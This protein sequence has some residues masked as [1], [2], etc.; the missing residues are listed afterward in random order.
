MKKNT[1]VKVN[2]AAIVSAMEAN[3]YYSR[4]EAD[5]RAH[6]AA[7]AARAAAY[8]AALDAAHRRIYEKAVAA[9]KAKKA[10]A[11]KAVALA[12]YERR[13]ASHAAVTVSTR[14]RK[15]HVIRFMGRL[16]REAEAEA[17]LH[18][19]MAGCQQTAKA[20]C[21]RA[22]AEASREALRRFIAGA[23]VA[24]GMFALAPEFMA[25]AI[26]AMQDIL[27]KLDIKYAKK[28]CDFNVDAWGEDTFSFT[29]HRFDG[30]ETTEEDGISEFDL[31][32]FAEKKEEKTEN[33]FGFDLQRFAK[34]TKKDPFAAHRTNVPLI[35]ELTKKEGVGYV[36]KVSFVR[37]TRKTLAAKVGVTSIEVNPV[38]RDFF[39]EGKALRQ[40]SGVKK[41]YKKAS[42]RIVVFEFSSMNRAANELKKNAKDSLAMPLYMIE[43]KHGMHV[44]AKYEG[45]EETPWG[46]ATTEIFTDLCTGKDVDAEIVKDAPMYFGTNGVAANSAGQ[47][48]N[49]SMLAFR[50]N[51]EADIKAYENAM[52]TAT[53]GESK[54]NRNLDII[55]GAERADINTRMGSKLT[56]LGMNAYMGVSIESYIIVL[57]KNART[58]GRL[59]YNAKGVAIGISQKYGG[60]GNIKKLTERVIGY[61]AQSRPYTVKG[62]GLI[63]SEEEFELD[64]RKYKILKLDACDPKNYAKLRQ[65]NDVLSKARRER[66]GIKLDSVPGFKGYDAVQICRGNLDATPVFYGDLNAFKDQFDQRLG[67]GLN[68]V[69]IPKGPKSFND[70]TLSNQMIKTVLRAAKDSDQ[71]DEFNRVTKELE[72]R[73]L[74]GI[75]DMKEAKGF[76]GDEML[77]VS[78]IG[79]LVRQLN[80]SDGSLKLFPSVYRTVIEDMKLSAENMIERDK[81]H[82]NGIVTMMTSDP[83]IE[84]FGESVLCMEKNYAEVF[85]PAFERYA[86]E[87]G[88]TSREGIAI[89]HPAMGTCELAIIRFVSEEEMVERIAKLAK[90]LDSNVDF[91]DV[92]TVQNT[93]RTL[94]EGTV[95]IPG[96]LQTF[97]MI[98]AGADL[99]GDELI[100]HYPAAD[101]I[102]YVHII[103]NAVKAGKFAWRAVSI[104]GKKTGKA[105]VSKADNSTFIEQMRENIVGGNVA[106]GSITNVHRIMNEPL[107]GDG[108]DVRKA[109][110]ALFGEVFGMGNL[111]RKGS[112]V[113]YVSPIKVETNEYDIE[114]FHTTEDIVDQVIMAMRKASLTWENVVAAA[115]DWDIIGRHNQELTI[116]AQKKYYSVEHMAYVSW[117]FRH[118]TVL[119]LKDHVHFDMNWES[120][121]FVTINKLKGY[122]QAEKS[123]KVSAH[124]YEIENDYDDEKSTIYVVKDSFADHRVYAINQA[125]K[126]LNALKNSYFEAV[127]AAKKDT[128]YISRAQKD[129]TDAG[130][131]S[132]LKVIKNLCTVA[133]FAREAA[134]EE[135]N[136]VASDDL[137]YDLSSEDLSKISDEV[138]SALNK[139][140]EEL[141]AL[142]SNEGRKLAKEYGQSSQKISY[143]LSN[144]LSTGSTL[145]KQETAKII[146]RYSEKNMV[147]YELFGKDADT[148]VDCDGQVVNVF[149]GHAHVAEGT[150]INGINLV[151]GGYKVEVTDLEDG[152]TKVELV[153]DT[154]DFIEIPEVDESKLVFLVEGDNS[155]EVGDKVNLVANKGIGNRASDKVEVCKN[156]KTVGTIKVAKEYVDA[157]T[158]RRNDR[159]LNRLDGVAGTVLATYTAPAREKY[160]ARTIVVLDVQKA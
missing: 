5:R 86:A 160:A 22:A 72:D 97:A 114:V 47:G 157:Y 116:D 12:R 159:M 120:T 80:P 122:T 25:T 87:N 135:M 1:N 79:G 121:G 77:D 129:L 98:V 30:V 11:K 101:G 92:V 48:R 123:G 42:D 117:V 59:A 64:T 107:L 133:Y 31:Q 89:K 149:N 139:V 142:I 19:L 66:K 105:N 58:D 78:Y 81:Y 49:F 126:H 35:R 130:M 7:K 84:A 75:F 128:K 132:D 23:T 109:F 124:S 33:G 40:F 14:P 144:G 146:C 18:R 6:R 106:V 103:W 36:Q 50:A 91:R 96:D 136:T 131:M 100:I 62:A 82:V 104:D 153:R 20:R 37:S 90:K 3:G 94:K 28:V 150:D 27:E 127:A 158:T 99:D 137:A 112:N 73:S 10:A 74:K 39:E 115:D 44:V 152:T 29:L 71:M 145:F 54:M 83:T 118:M 56:G 154:A 68:I 111:T 21:V 119:P 65:L 69:A 148:L 52:A 32:L 156:K 43:T 151:N 2:A 51:D 17:A 141:L 110:A 76:T 95:L 108:K 34:K 61:L 125:L 45:S 26:F 147:R 13:V 88:V 57:N 155:I 24:E 9:A 53:V 55:T 138:R 143:Y 41:V 46:E 15:P 8:A 4:L 63:L 140:Y 93:I 102:D 113:K 134:K 38:N 16:V 70:T 67:D 85:D 60:A